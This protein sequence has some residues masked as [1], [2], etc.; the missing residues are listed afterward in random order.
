LVAFRNFNYSTH[1][2]VTKTWAADG[3][4]T[5]LHEF[6]S[7]AAAKRLLVGPLDMA[8]ISS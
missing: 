5:V 6:K 8:L 1:P 4:G 7:W 2:T 3:I